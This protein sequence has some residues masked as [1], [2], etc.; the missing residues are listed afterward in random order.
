MADLVADAPLV[1]R[2]RE[3]AQALV[4][5]DP[6]LTRPEHRTLAAALERYSLQHRLELWVA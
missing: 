3:L 1:A 5:T 2:T 4:A 6:D